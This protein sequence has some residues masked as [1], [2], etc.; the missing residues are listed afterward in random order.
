MRVILQIARKHVGVTLCPGA[1]DIIPCKKS[2]VLSI[3]H[4]IGEGGLGKQRVRTAVVWSRCEKPGIRRA[5]VDSG[6]RRLEIVDIARTAVRT[7]FLFVRHELG[8][9]RIDIERRGCCGV[10]RR[11]LVEK[12][13]EPHEV[14]AVTEVQTPHSV[15]DDLVADIDLIG[16]RLL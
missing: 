13:C 9:L 3:S 7:A 15:V 16:Q 5:Q 11:H 14:L 2:A 4:V 12:V 1:V 6:L 10:Y 8:E